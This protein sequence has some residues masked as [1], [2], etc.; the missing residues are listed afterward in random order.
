MGAPAYAPD[1][2]RLRAAGGL[3]LTTLPQCHLL[4]VCVCMCAQANS[5][6]VDELYRNCPS[7]VAQTSNC[8]SL[9]LTLC[10]SKSKCV[11]ECTCVCVCLPPAL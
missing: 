2:G 9:E 3:V 1:G 6:L 8:M 11:C 5:Q 7:N 10:L 4:S